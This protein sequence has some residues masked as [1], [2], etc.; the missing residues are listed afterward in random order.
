[1]VDE[2]LGFENRQAGL[3]WTGV[4]WL[5]VGPGGKVTVST[6][7]WSAGQEKPILELANKTATDFMLVACYLFY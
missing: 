1:M 2:V 4:K 6:L 5:L 7:K 3:P